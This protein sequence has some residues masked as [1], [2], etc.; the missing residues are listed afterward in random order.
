M[1]GLK[2]TLNVLAV[3]Q[4]LTS[5][6]KKEAVRLL[7]QLKRMAPNNHRKYSLKF[8]TRLFNNANNTL[9]SHRLTNTGPSGLRAAGAVAA[10]TGLRGGAAGTNQPPNMRKVKENANK[11]RRA[12]LALKAEQ[13]ARAAIAARRA[14]KP[15]PFGGAIPENIVGELTQNIMGRVVARGKE[16]ENVAAANKNL[17]KML[18]NAQRR[19]QPPNAPPGR[20]PN[21]KPVNAPANV[22]KENLMASI[23]AIYKASENGENVNVPK[24]RLLLSQYRAKRGRFTRNT[25]TNAKTIRNLE[26]RLKF[27]EAI[28]KR[29]ARGASSVAPV[30]LPRAVLP[31]PINTSILA[32]TLSRAIKAALA[33][34]KSG[35]ARPP[36]TINTRSLAST[37]AAAIKKALAARKTTAGINTSG[38]VAALTTAIKK[39]LAAR[40]A[41]VTA[42]GT[43]PVTAKGPAPV[44]AKGPAPVNT[45]ALASSLA[46]AITDALSK[47]KPAAAQEPVRGNSGRRAEEE[48]A[49]QTRKGEEAPP[50]KINKNSL[51]KALTNALKRALARPGPGNTPPPPEKPAKPA[52]PTN[53]ANPAKPAKPTKPTK[54]GAPGAPGKTGGN[55]N[56]FNG[57]QV[58]GPVSLTGG[59]VTTSVTGPKITG[60]TITGPTITGPTITGPTITGPS[61]TGPSITGPT[62]SMTGPTITVAAPNIKI[63]LN[64]LVKA[65][66]QARN[67]P[68]KV[69][70]LMRQVANLKARLGNGTEAKK[71]LNT[72]FPKNAPPPTPEAV[73]TV[74]TTVIAKEEAKKQAAKKE[75][76]QT[77][78]PPGKSI[79]N[80]AFGELLS[81]RRT[82]KNR[83]EINRYLR[84]DV[85]NELK[86]IERMSS[87]ERGW[88]LGELYRS[89]PDS[90]PAKARVGR[91][92]Q[93]EIRRAGR[94]RD[95]V[96]ASRRLR[97]LYGNL[98][99]GRR[100]PREFAREFKTQNM[101]AMTNYKRDEER[102]ARK[103]GGGSLRQGREMYRTMRPGQQMAL[104]QRA[105]MRP[106]V[107][108][109]TQSALRQG[110]ARPLPSIKGPQIFPGPKSLVEGVSLKIPTGIRG[111][112]LPSNQQSAIAKAGGPTQ[113]L[114]VVAAVPGGAPAV[115]RA[116]ADMNEMNG[117]VKK[118]R[119]LKGTP[120]AAIKA[121]QKLGGAKTASYALEGLNTLAQSKKTQA[122]KASPG[123]KVRKVKKAPLRLHE[124]NKVIEAVKR[125]KLVS[126]VTHNV[127]NV[128]NNKKKKYY[129]K[130]I[131]S[132]ILKKSLANKVQAAAKKNKS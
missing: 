103:Y 72:L 114:K 86:K 9:V 48:P 25:P 102:Y 61:I 68:N 58:G 49:R 52:K 131:K 78:P 7:L 33:K 45:S 104:T 127:G 70:N 16:R 93:A 128:N 28:K 106:A 50:P 2:S 42:K 41:P 90:L 69:A 59:A 65:T 83:V 22:T 123:K 38:L 89:L 17:N 8:G 118:A 126:L 6:N 80:M 10:L 67:N 20:R 21:A 56:K 40:K 113:A 3:K 12:A 79:K 13:N 39:A 60:P 99:M 95:P 101:R 124:L 107:A 87:S 94:E 74:V 32:A 19:A 35:A 55:A 36:Q 27:Y 96:E 37:L 57:R 29:G 112:V 26:E 77:P 119:E 14:A 54:P 23:R 110:G 44:T 75:F 66:E 129:K 97:D 71:A 92:I 4:P 11:A 81:M 130:V 88:R 82:S 91:A 53:P 115:A 121:V 5:N 98:G 46:G 116:A 85:D 84:Q 105:P 120:I 63:Q 76:K 111:P 30:K 132:F 108:R 18:E 34:P 62:T 31:K 51:V 1:N 117:N 43:A 24:A 73:K 15:S 100:L 64:G 47:R 125:K 109:A 122:R